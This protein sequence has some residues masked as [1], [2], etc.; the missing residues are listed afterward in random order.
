DALG[1]EALRAPSAPLDRLRAA[2]PFALTPAQERVL[3]EVAR[4]LEAPRPMRRL[5][6]GDVGSGKT[7][8]AMLAAAHAVAAGAQVALM[9]PTEVLAEQLFRALAPLAKALALR[10]AL[11][12]G[13][14]RAS[15]R[16]D[17][18][19]GLADGTIDVALGTHALLSEGLAFR[20]L[21]LAIVDEQH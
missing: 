11:V 7:A 12:V 10:M 2:L 20:R 13:G 16:R 21:R 14:A 17:V 18:R 6:Q 8:V 5:L 3:A 9:A 4:D 1:A 19:S 15:H